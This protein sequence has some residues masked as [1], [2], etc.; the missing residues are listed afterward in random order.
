MSSLRDSLVLV[1]AALPE[2][3]VGLAD[4]ER[5]ARLA[6]S[7]A[8]IHCAGFEVRLTGGDRA[9]DLAQ[10][11]VA[12]DGE[13][14]RLARHLE[15][16]CARA[17]PPGWAE[18]RDFAQR[19][20]HAQSPPHREI[21]GAW[22]EFAAD[23]SQDAAPALFVS[24]RRQVEHGEAPRLVALVEA[25]MRELAGVAPSAALVA[26]LETAVAAC[27]EGAGIA[28]IGVLPGRA[29]D[30]VRLTTAELHP[31]DVGGYLDAI[32]WPGEPASLRP[33]RDA[34]RDTG[35]LTVAFDATG[36]TPG[37]APRIGIECYPGPYPADLPRWG[38]LL[39]DLVDASRCH[40]AARDALLAWPGHTTPDPQGAPWPAAL[41]AESLLR[42]PREFSV[43]GRRLDH[44][45]IV[46]DEAGV[47]HA[48][49]YFG[50]GPLWLRPEDTPGSD[51]AAA[52]LTPPV[53]SRASPGRS[54]GTR[55]VPRRG[56]QGSRRLCAATGRGNPDGPARAGRVDAGRADASPAALEA[57]I[58]G[59][60]AWLVER[61]S[62][63]GCWRDF[64]A[65]MGGSDEWVT[66]YAA[67]ELA[68]AP[69]GAGR[70]A[71]QRAWHWLL[72]RRGADDG[73][74]FNGALPADADG[75]AWGLA[76][77]HALEVDRSPRAVAAASVLRRHATAAGG[78]ASYVPAAAP[79][80]A[81]TLG[82]VSMAGLFED[83]TC[84]S[85]AAALL[86][87][88][89][90]RVH[91]FL[92]HRQHDDGR[93]TGYWWCDD[94]Y[95]TGLA[96]PA[97][98]RRGRR[99]M[100]TAPAGDVHE[101]APAGDAHEGR[102]DREPGEDRCDADAVQRA[103]AWVRRRARGG[104][105]ISDFSAAPSPFATAA[106]GAALLAAEGPGR[107]SSVSPAA[108]E[109]VRWLLDRQHA[110]GSW[111]PSAYMRIPPPDARTPPADGDRT[112]VG[113]DDAGIFTTA[114]VLRTLRL[115]LMR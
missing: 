71:A 39:D 12:F 5:L 109:L 98:C 63:A 96:A 66:A 35:G 97:L 91:D 93:W 22:L 106:G 48:K 49:A 41:V 68:A 75:T 104:A 103:A 72:D 92:C 8:P 80:L 31:D 102:R 16:A 61:Q 113:I 36:G 84:V 69:S 100:R 54:S 53:A 15:A 115:A 78:F 2:E 9:V 28:D 99:G 58:D 52:S 59:A 18:L 56:Q 79:V 1:L 51:P 32:G 33:L 94:E 86:P 89:D 101:P 13:P 95:A 111:E 42:D 6:A 11:I 85:A 20:R 74:G 60:V 77:A 46:C 64:D 34:L 40:P 45:K 26:T 105:I 82:E 43:I 3:I 110:D 25:L 81:D 112:F 55:G 17:A 57:A 38:R 108:S 27:P 44:V 67:T 83:H 29:L 23:A 47:R 107:S 88:T 50:F 4:Q 30:A 87:G 65:V 114:T 10:R 19:W 62:E 70:N 14:T 7:L 90:A 37:V 76:L 21:V 24:L 73:W